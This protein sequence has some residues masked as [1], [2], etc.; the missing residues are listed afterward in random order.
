MKFSGTTR[1]LLTCLVLIVVLFIIVSLFEIVLAVL[2]S[3]FYSP[4]A[5]IVTF[6]VG[7]VFA[8]TIGYTYA[9]SLAPVKN[10][11]ARWSLFTLLKI[12][13]LLFFFPLAKI[14][15]GEYEA[16]FKAYG[17]TMAISSLPFAKRKID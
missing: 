10:E 11:F 17:A 8:S 6:G 13:G 15:G 2:Y 3:L 9:I 4:S 16:A 5:F 1:A 14:E 7:G 12:T